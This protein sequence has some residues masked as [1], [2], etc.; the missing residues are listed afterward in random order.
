MS[1]VSCQSPECVSGVCA[2]GCFL[3]GLGFPCLPAGLILVHHEELALGQGLQAALPLNS[4]PSE[5]TL[6]ICTSGLSPWWQS[7]SYPAFLPVPGLH[8]AWEAAVPVLPSVTVGLF[9]AWPGP[10][11][12]PSSHSCLLC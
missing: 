5:G 4:L 6:L 3:L 9:P 1:H 7:T 10:A 11:A 2:G 8:K 12:L